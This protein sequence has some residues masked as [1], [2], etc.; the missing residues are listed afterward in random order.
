MIFDG[1]DLYMMKNFLDYYTEAKIIPFSLPP[2]SSQNLQPLNIVVF[3]PFKH[4]YY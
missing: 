4:Y 1:F 3:E 2:Y